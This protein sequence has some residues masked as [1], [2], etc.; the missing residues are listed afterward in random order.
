M[1]CTRATVMMSGIAY[2]LQSLPLPLCSEWIM[3]ATNSS[4]ET[5]FWHIHL[6]FLNDL[7]GR[8][9][10]IA[11]PPCG[12]TCSIL[13]EPCMLQT[14]TSNCLQALHSS[15]IAEG[16]GDHAQQPVHCT[17][18]LWLFKRSS[19]SRACALIQQYRCPRFQ[20]S[21]RSSNKG[22]A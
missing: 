12:M 20:C 7:F 2:V 22:I 11:R 15:H 5:F 10:L 21:P 18:S 13:E 1:P 6:P 19:G 16:N 14:Y 17:L 9:A 4:L 3:L 8:S